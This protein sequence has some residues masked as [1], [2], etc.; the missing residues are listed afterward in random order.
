MFQYAAAKS[1]LKS[2][3]PV[4]LDHQFLENNNINTDHFTA[5]KYELDIF[6][7]LK[8]RHAGKGLLRLLKDQ[9]FLIR[10]LRFALAVKY[11][12]QVDN[13]FVP[14]ANL[15]GYRY[16]Y[17]NGYFQSEKYFI[18]KR[19]EII[20]DFQ[21]PQL[22]QINETIK[23]AILNSINP[24]SIHIRRGD[25]LKT[26]TNTIHGI[27]PVNYYHKALDVLQ[28]KYPEIIL[29]IFSDD[30]NWAK[31]NLKRDNTT[32]HFVKHN[33]TN[34]AWKDMALMTY[35]KHHII[36]NSSFSWWGAWLSKNNGSVFA[37]KNWF[38]PLKVNFNICDFIPD[39]WTIINYD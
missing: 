21:F 4:Y 28:L 19:E 36:A 12:Q 23:N 14:L 29:F 10:L 11:I 26:H 3:E 13:E 8:A 30:I 7:N 22:D 20:N 38:N 1:L 39:N 37:P 27:L 9:S 25:Y 24:V 18:D 34:G 33:E 5:R 31:E 16:L 6:K 15:S 32:L 2:G 35:C 17:L